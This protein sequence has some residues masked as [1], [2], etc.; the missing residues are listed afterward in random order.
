MRKN[1]KLV[2][3]K[4]IFDFTTSQFTSNQDDIN[5]AWQI[6]EKDFLIQP[7]LSIVTTKKYGK[8]EWNQFDNIYQ[9]NREVTTKLAEMKFGKKPMSISKGYAKI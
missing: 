1:L 3:E 4:I 2:K 9:K 7:T 5:I 6:N 8:F